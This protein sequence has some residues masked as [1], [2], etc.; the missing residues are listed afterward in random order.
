MLKK[1]YEIKKSSF[2]ILLFYYYLCTANFKNNNIY[3]RLSRGKLQNLGV[4]VA[5]RQ[6]SCHSTIVTYNSKKTDWQQ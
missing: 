2:F 1:R 3:G 4:R 6:S 5:R